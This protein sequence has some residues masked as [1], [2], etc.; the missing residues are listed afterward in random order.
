MTRHDFYVIRNFGGSAHGCS[1]KACFSMTTAWC[2]TSFFIFLLPHTDQG[3]RRSRKTDLP[4]EVPSFI[5]LK[6]P[7]HFCGYFLP[8]DECGLTLLSSYR[9]RASLRLAS[10][11]TL[12]SF[13]HFKIT[14][15]VKLR[16]VVA[17]NTGELSID[18]DRCIQL[19]RNPGTRDAG[20]GHQA[21]VFSAAIIIHLQN[22]AALEIVRTI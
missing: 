5:M 1:G 6:R 8:S 7:A 13:A 3:H 2:I 17:E 20:V 18:P 15:Q 16:S 12:F 11:K 10:S 9:H 21:K 14:R 19:P 22:I 4:P